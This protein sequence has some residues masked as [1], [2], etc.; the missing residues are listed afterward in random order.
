MMY[1]L[2]AHGGFTPP[3]REQPAGAVHRTRSQ[4]SAPEI[5]RRAI[6]VRA[7]SQSSRSLSRWAMASMI[8]MSSLACY[9]S[10]SQWC[11][12]TLLHCGS[13]ATLSRTLET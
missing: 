4:G 9:D 3:R 5:T 8:T 7:P 1:A 6:A 2:E 10:S 11:R 12:S 13:M